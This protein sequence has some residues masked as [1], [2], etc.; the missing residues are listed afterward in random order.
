MRGG[1]VGKGGSEGWGTGADRELSAARDHL[2]VF[3]KASNG[4]VSERNVCPWPQALPSLERR[5]AVRG[6]LCATSLRSQAV[7]RVPPR[8]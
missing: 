2:V 8:S 6:D 1:S 3:A 7:G 5:G 4:N